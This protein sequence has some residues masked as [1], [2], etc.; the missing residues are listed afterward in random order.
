MAAL[1]YV[2]HVILILHQLLVLKQ[3]LEFCNK[4]GSENNVLF[5]AES[6]SYFTT[7]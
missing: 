1:C 4:F 3:M 6:T 5:N 7:Q 2:D